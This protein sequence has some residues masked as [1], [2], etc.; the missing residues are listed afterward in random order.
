MFL[1]QPTENETRIWSYYKIWSE[2]S[3]LSLEEKVSLTCLI[4]NSKQIKEM[5]T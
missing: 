2:T 4:V 5:L 3:Q 1:S